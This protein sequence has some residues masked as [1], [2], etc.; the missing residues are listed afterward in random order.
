M[1]KLLL[2]ID[3]FWF[4]PLTFESFCNKLCEILEPENNQYKNNARMADKKL[5]F[6]LTIDR[7]AMRYKTLKEFKKDF[8]ENLGINDTEEAI[9]AIEHPLYS[10]KSRGYSKC[11]LK[12]Y[13]NI[14]QKKTYDLDIN[15][16]DIVPRSNVEIITNN[17]IKNLNKASF[18]FEKPENIATNIPQD[19]IHNIKKLNGELVFG[20]NLMNF[21]VCFFSNFN[22]NEFE[23]NY[24]VKLYESYN[25]EFDHR[26]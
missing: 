26:F 16:D 22:L 20:A 23:Y 3:L 11:A 21:Y 9:A 12:I 24:L 15:L 7:K 5:Y 8:F 1:Q 13:L 17:L 25:L 18:D 14:V 19:C 10:L 4:K 6:A 2:F